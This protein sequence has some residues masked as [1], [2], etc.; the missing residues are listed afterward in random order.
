MSFMVGHQTSKFAGDPFA[1]QGVWGTPNGRAN[2]CE[3]DYAITF[4]IAE[5]INSLS[6]VAYVYLALKSIYPTRSHF[7]TKPKIDFMSFSLLALGI[8]SFLFHASLRKTLEFVDE[9]SMLLLSWSM[10]DAVFAADISSPSNRRLVRGAIAV[11]HII[12]CAVYL[13]TV[14]IIIQ[15]VGFLGGMIITGFKSHY[16]LKGLKTSDPTD[17]KKLSEAKAK[18]LTNRGWDAVYVSLF[19]YLLWNIEFMYCS[20]LRAAKA[21]IG[22][23]TSWIFEFH[24]WWHVLTAIGAA[25]FMDVAR[26][27]RAE[28]RRQMGTGQEK[29]EK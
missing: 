4:Y 20:E 25:Q 21:A 22:L 6:N 5:F 12:F 26:E 7:P 16:L 9:L 28:V 8:G 3:E 2:F 11:F 18:D 1:S 29:K 13:Q 17:E 19:G 27:M 10:L 24:G 23:P 15:V 14:N